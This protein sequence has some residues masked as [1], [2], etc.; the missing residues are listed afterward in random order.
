M[1]P[2]RIGIW[3]DS[4]HVSFGGPARVLIGTLLG[5]L[6]DTE[7]PC[8]LRLNE[9]GDINWIFN[10]SNDT[11][12]TIDVQTRGL[13]RAAGPM[14]FD[15]TQALLTSEEAQK[16]SVWR[17]GLTQPTLYLAP[18]LWFAQWIA[19]GLPFADPMYATTHPMTVWGAGVDTEFFR[20]LEGAIAPR[21][22]YFIY[23]KS[24]DWGA[25][26]DIH[27][28][29]MMNYFGLHGPVLVYYF[30]NAKELLGMS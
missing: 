15:A 17:L 23:F 25:L 28:Y 20:P 27:T 14:V 12:T 22:T 10:V 19:H 13:P 9:A 3:F 26:R 4:S 7:N 30:Y 5:W 11:F 29:L 1:H 21:H 6:Q 24:Q 2:Q 18:S 16:E 8:I